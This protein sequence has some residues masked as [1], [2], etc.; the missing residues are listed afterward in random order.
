MSTSKP[1]RACSRG[2]PYRHEKR[3]YISVTPCFQVTP[4]GFTPSAENQTLTS[5]LAT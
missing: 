3:S 5:F 2:V 1:Y 4:E